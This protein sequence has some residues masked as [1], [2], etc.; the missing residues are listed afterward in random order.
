MLQYLLAVTRH[1]TESAVA[2][3]PETSGITAMHYG[4]TVAFTGNSFLIYS[5]LVMIQ[6]KIVDTTFSGTYTIG[7]GYDPIFSVVFAMI[8]YI[9]HTVN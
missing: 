5:S 2:L 6:L 8:S 1:H 3:L 4:Q 9:T 7:F